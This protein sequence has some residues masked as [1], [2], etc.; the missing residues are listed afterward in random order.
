MKNFQHLCAEPNHRKKDSLYAQK[1]KAPIDDDDLEAELG[2]FSLTSAM[3]TI[4]ITN[5][6][7]VPVIATASVAVASGTGN[8]PQEADPQRDVRQI[9][10]DLI[11]TESSMSK[12]RIQEGHQRMRERELEVVSKR[13]KSFELLRLQE[14]QCINI[15]SLVLDMPVSPINNRPRIIITGDCSVSHSGVQG[16]G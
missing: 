2:G 1:M 11:A 7:A 6:E 3:S 12:L 9:Q 16:R 4:V 10:L 13:N 8:D 5:A 15:C 14:V